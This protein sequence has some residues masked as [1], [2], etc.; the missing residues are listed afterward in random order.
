[1]ESHPVANLLPQAAS[2]AAT[3]VVTLFPKSNLSWATLQHSRIRT[4]K[5]RLR[6]SAVMAWAVLPFCPSIRTV[7]KSSP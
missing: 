7:G 6:S 3:S 5:P 2:A 1:M 4:F